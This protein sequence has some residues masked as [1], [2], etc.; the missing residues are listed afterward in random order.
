MENNT[1]FKNAETKRIYEE[2]YFNRDKEWNSDSK[3]YYIGT[4]FGKTFIRESGKGEALILLHPMNFTSLWYKSAVA[5]LSKYYR[6]LAVDTVGDLGKSYQSRPITKADDFV[7]WQKELY[8]QLGLES[9]FS[10]I[11][12]S[13]GAWIGSLYAVENRKVRKLVIIS[14]ACVTA[15]LSEQYLNALN[16]ISSTEELFEWFLQDLM[17]SSENREEVL[18]GIVRE[19]AF[20][21][22]Y[23]D[24]EPLP[25]PTRL[26]KTEMNSIHAETLYL[27]GRNEKLYDPEEGVSYFQKH[28]K[29]SVS[30]I[31]EGAGHDLM[32]VKGEIIKEKV[33]PFLNK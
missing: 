25:F 11:G 22:N 12:S 23:F 27:V 24:V 26:S 9:D 17:E 8:Q 10:I 13:Y 15:H 31:I 3:E 7:Q 29:N 1:P 5:E 14:P 20:R 19:S 18:A 30:E 16:S 28:M 21:E 6:V 33:I 4:D 2:Y 32:L